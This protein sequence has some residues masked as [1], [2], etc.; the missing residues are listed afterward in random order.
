MFV[1]RTRLLEILSSKDFIWFGNIAADWQA[2]QHECEDA[3]QSNPNYWTDL[4]SV[5]DSWDGIG[6]QYNNAIQMGRDWGYTKENTR[7]WET[8]AQKQ[9]IRM[10]WEPDI[11][12]NL[13]LQNGINRP[14]LQPPGTTMPWHKDHFWYF[15]RQY[16]DNQQFIVRF[17]V[18][19]SD[20]S[21][22]HFIQA[23]NSVIKSWLAG[24]VVLWHPDR[25]H[26]ATNAGFANKW[27][28]NITGI[29]DETIE[30]P[31]TI[32]KEQL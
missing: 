17:I 6:D 4:V 23:G 7:S 16:P 13:P 24:D 30:I 25:M 28:S 11:V 2:I 1:S 29:L 3:V 26:L 15:K 22:G 12:T 19:I 8:T 20:W 9:Q 18:F 10:Q 14:T 31:Y 21:P 32:A 5:V 27:T